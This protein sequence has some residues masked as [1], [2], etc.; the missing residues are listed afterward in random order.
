MNPTLIWALGTIAVSA[1]LLTP[2]ALHDPKRLRSLRATRRVAMASAMRTAL[3]CG[4][5]LPGLVTIAAE[6][7]PAFLIWLGAVSAIGWSLA[8]GFAINSMRGR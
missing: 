7:W 5:L 1:V 2:L 6:Q 3:G 4:S 8:Q